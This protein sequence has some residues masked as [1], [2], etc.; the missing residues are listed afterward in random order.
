MYVHS[1]DEVKQVGKGNRMRAGRLEGKVALITGA[2]TG[3][4]RTAARLFAGEGAS[5]VVA[6]IVR[7]LGEEVAAGIAAD[8]GTAS[9]EHVDIREPDSVQAALA[10]AVREHGRIDILYNN[11]GGS[12]LNDGPITDVSIEEFWR[13]MKLDLFG[14][15][16]V[17]KF[18]IPR[19][20][21]AGGGAIVNT[22]SLL[23]LTGYAGK[24]AYIPAKGAVASL[25]RS[26]ALEYAGAGIRVNAVAPG[27][28]DTDRG[29]SHK[30]AGNIPGAVL[31]RHLH[32]QVKPEEVALAALY[33]ASDEARTVTG[34]IL[35]I[36]SGYMVS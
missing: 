19:L 32:G 1:V 24:D 13:C 6:D 3:I 34:T 14:T 28:V 4:G 2:A 11:A 30:A 25:T 31:E 26:L 27:S 7:D 16:L 23:A 18:G 5:V 22:T 12:T 10:G 21:D 20:I 15:W 9:F 29:R 36:D 17:C 35:R 8:G 33:L